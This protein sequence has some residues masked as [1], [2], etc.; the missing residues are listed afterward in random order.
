MVD[1]GDGVR[2]RVVGDLLG[3]GHAADPPGVDLHVAERPVLDEVDR[4]RGVVRA[5]A[6]REPHLAGQLRESSVG[7]IGIFHERLLE[8][9][10]AA[11][12]QDR[13]AHSRRLEVLAEDGA[14]VDQQDAVVADRLARR[15]DL[16]DV[17]LHGSAT[18]GTPAELDGSEPRGAGCATL[19][20]GLGRRVAEERRCV[21]RLG[22]RAL[23]AEQLPDG[24]LL[25]PAEQVPE[26]HVDAR[27]DVIGL[28]QVE[29]LRAHEVADAAD[30]GSIVQPLAEHR[31]ADGLAGAVRERAD[32]RCDRRERCRLALAVALE[33]PAAHAH[34]Q[35]VLAAV[36]DVEHLGH[37][38][39]E[40][41]DRLNAH[42]RPRERDGCASQQR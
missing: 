29:A 19:R 17:V 30:V 25:T 28:Q 12:A 9:G 15:D 36:A 20:Q 21:R 26:R 38:E 8:P 16:V 10:R 2:C 1:V 7:A 41:L 33:A 23:V 5:L 31:C 34:E 39:V 22:V 35:G 13:S 4:H 42:W 14:G 6:A 40:E 24:C 11:L 37:R 27:E 18:E 3:C 32:E